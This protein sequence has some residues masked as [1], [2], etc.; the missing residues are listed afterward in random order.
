MIAKFASGP[1][2]ARRCALRLLL[3][4]GLCARRLGVAVVAS[5]L[6]LPVQT[7]WPQ[8]AT[9]TD[10]KA[11]SPRQHLIQ[12]RER[13]NRQQ[14]KRLSD[15]VEQAQDDALLGSYA[16]YWLLRWRTQDENQRIPVQALQDFIQTSKNG[17]LVER[18]KAEWL[19]AASRE[20]DYATVL[21]LWPIPQANAQVQCAW[22]TAR[23]MA[24]QKVTQDDAL[25]A[26]EAGPA[27][28]TM[29]ERLVAAK[30][31][32]WD[33]LRAQLRAILETSQNANARRMAALMFNPDEMASYTALMKDPRKWLQGRKAPTGRAQTELVTLALSRLAREANRN[34]AAD[35]VQTQWAK[36]VPQAQLQWVWSQFGLIAALNVEN[37]A[38]QWYRRSGTAALTDY[39]HAWQVR[40]E[41]RKPK[42]E[43]QWVEHAIRRMSPEQQAETAWTY[44]LG[45]A[46]AAQG[47]E[48]EARQHYV[49]IRHVFDFYGQLAY[50]ELG[51]IQPLPSVPPPVTQAELAAARAHPGLRRAVALFA[52]GWRTEAV[53]EWNYALRDMDDRMLRAAAELARAEQIFD[54]VINTS[55]RTQTEIDFSQRFIAP[56]AEQVREKA[57]EID[58]DPAWVFGLIRQESRFITNARSSVGA[59]GLMQLMPATAKWVAKKIGMEDFHPSSVNDFDV[60]TVL[61]TRYLDMV[62][63]DLDGSQVL[64]SAGY[65]AGPKRSVR[66]RA[67]LQGPVEGAIFAETIPFTETR[68]YVKH[69]LSNATYYA[70]LFS[71]E[72]QSLKARLGIITPSPQRAVDLP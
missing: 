50:E 56:F 41:L 16:S 48:N 29:L 4:W 46:L 32:G 8:G 40:A 47:K 9:R 69:V 18:L 71:G 34:A 52:L 70:T 31:V 35:L 44:W 49:S 1:V 58:L 6:C 23:H 7:A 20:G 25:A 27:C 13:V 10:L 24:G 51:G 30:V 11:Q 22:H 5:V 60:N 12:L 33:A 61:G 17:L 26:F 55:L 2:C 42:I 45:R 14:W 54:R 19:L 72:P 62:L 65:N 64:A 66:W 63:R 67:A 57:R 37:Q 38:Y 59:S 21:K 36:R 68:L 53:Q 15:L 28:W 39:N 3:A 43:W